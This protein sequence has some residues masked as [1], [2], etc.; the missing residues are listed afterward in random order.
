MEKQLLILCFSQFD[1]DR[2]LFQRPQQVMFRLS[3]KFKILWIRRLSFRFL[4]KKTGP[5]GDAKNFHIN[6]NL[7]VFN[8]I[9]LPTLYGHLPLIGYIN[10][11][12]LRFF[13]KRKVKKMQKIQ[14]MP[15]ISWFYYPED[16]MLAGKLG[17]Q[18]IVYECMDEFAAFRRAP[19]NMKKK[20]EQLLSKA[21]VVFVGGMRMYRRKKKHNSNVH[22]FPTGVDFNHFASTERKE[23]EIPDDVKMLPHPILGY[24]GAVDERLDYELL[25]YL[26]EKRP[27][28]SLVLLGPLTKVKYKE[29]A[30]CLD[31]PNVHWLGA[32]DYSLLPNYG[33]AFDLC[34]LPFVSTK[35]AENLN[36]TKTLEY[37]A[38]GAPVAST[39]LDD[40]NELYSDVVSIA[41]NKEEFLM[42]AEDALA[43]DSQQRRKARKDFAR[44][45]SWEAM[46]D[47]MEKVVLE[48]CHLNE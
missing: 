2:T 8:P 42:A 4:F 27:E 34:L 43:K 12:L 18:G 15:T 30:F 17:D 44:E 39:A 14:K 7:Q 47:G 28:W 23:T 9:M 29:V 45:K 25:N 1:W 20:D 36:P 37:L 26:A 33:K 38:M 46:V 13:I 31:R 16:V 24:W 5:T 35:E 21:N 6:E 11:I 10:T 19:K 22:F 32:K 40:I 41:Q 3:K 48:T